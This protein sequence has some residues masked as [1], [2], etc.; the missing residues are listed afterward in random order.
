MD[1]Y[2]WADPARGSAFSIAR[3]GYPFIAAAA[4]VTLI[5]SLT[6][7]KFLTIAALFVTGFICAFFRDPDR[8]TPDIENTVICPAD[9]RVVSATVVEKN[10]FVDGPCMKVGIFMNVFNVHVNRIP[11]SGAIES[12]TYRPGRFLSADKAEASIANEHN[13]LVIRMEDGVRVGVVQIA[14][15]IARRIICRVFEKDSVTA[16]SRFGM[17]CFGSRVDLYLPPDTR[18][19]VSV[20]DKVKAGSTIIGYLKQEDPVRVESE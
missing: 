15:F 12:I 3:P 17:I 16:G 4:F 18:I 19:A 10:P 1:K 7:L 6:G 14:G 2:I 11:V 9:G 20:G 8:V 13:A 5:L